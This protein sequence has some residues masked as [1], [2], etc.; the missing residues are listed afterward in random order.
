MTKPELTEKPAKRKSKRRPNVAAIETKE[1]LAEIARRLDAAP[2]PQPTADGV[3]VDADYVKRCLR[4][5][6]L[7]ARGSK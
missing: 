3:T 6:G 1:L 7:R 4:D 2:V 5:S